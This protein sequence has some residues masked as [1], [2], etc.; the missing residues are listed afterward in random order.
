MGERGTPGTAKVDRPA[1]GGG[2][3]IP[4]ER[5][6][7]RASWFKRHTELCRHYC[8]SSSEYYFFLLFLSPGASSLAFAA[9]V[10]CLM[11]PG[12]F[13]D[14]PGSFG[15]LG[16][17]RWPGE[18]ADTPPLPPAWASCEAKVAT[19]SDTRCRP[20]THAAPRGARSTPRTHRSG[21]A[22]WGCHRCAHRLRP[23]GFAAGGNGSRDRRS[24][25]PPQL[26]RLQH[27]GTPW[28]PWDGETHH[29]PGG[30]SSGSAVE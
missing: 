6:S 11:S 23:L 20:A 27:L 7:R 12:A 16:G 4:D 1:V 9:P 17:G 28:N 22:G 30:S 10:S 15:P 26:P 18:L 13:A 8:G 24:E 29:T 19:T 14:L 21:R 2:D 3:K 25:A 5:R